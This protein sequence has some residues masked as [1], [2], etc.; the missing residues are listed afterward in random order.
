MTKVTD[1]KRAKEIIEGGFWYEVNENI[2]TILP[3]ASDSDKSN[4]EYIEID[5]KKI[6]LSKSL[7][8]D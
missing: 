3:C 2:L 1:I 6:D 7:I 5:L 8:I 4:Y